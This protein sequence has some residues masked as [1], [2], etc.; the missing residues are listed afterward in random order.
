MLVL[1][2]FECSYT[3]KT[4]HTHYTYTHRHTHTTDTPFLEHPAYNS[5]LTSDELDS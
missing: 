3:Y 4:L 5:W 1:F 2:N